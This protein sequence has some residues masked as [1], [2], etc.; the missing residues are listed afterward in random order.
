[1]MVHPASHRI[2]RVLWY[3]GTACAA[4]R[5]RLRGYH[6]LWPAIPRRF[7][8]LVTDHVWRPYNP[9]GPKSFGLAY[10][11]FARHYWGNLV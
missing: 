11:P 2:T 8:Y 7:G 6:P 9:K 1:M 5:F 3:S 4:C 10:S